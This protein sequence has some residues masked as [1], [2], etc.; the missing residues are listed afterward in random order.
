M[1][2]VATNLRRNSRL[3]SGVSYLWTLRIIQRLSVI[4][5]LHVDHINVIWSEYHQDRFIKAGFALQT[6]LYNDHAASL[7]KSPLDSIYYAVV[8][9]H[10]PLMRAIA[11]LHDVV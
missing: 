8:S 4:C 11:F 3:M 10:P 7:L 1:S 9:S 5:H 2:P 6:W